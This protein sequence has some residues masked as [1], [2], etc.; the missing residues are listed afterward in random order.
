[1]RLSEVEENATLADDEILLGSGERV[2]VTF[3]WRLPVQTGNVVQSDR[4]GFD[5]TLGLESA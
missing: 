4:V 1:V 3:E 2:T 5:L